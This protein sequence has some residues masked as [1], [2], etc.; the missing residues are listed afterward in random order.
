MAKKKRGGLLFDDVK[1]A[2]GGFFS[3]DPQENVSGAQQAAEL[4]LGFVPGV[5]QAL[6][7]RDFERARRAGDKAGMAL[8][9]ASLA[10]VGRFLPDASVLKRD[11]FIGPKARTWNKA[12]AE[13][14]AKLEKAGVNKEEIW[15]R[16]GTFR[17]L[18]KKWRQEISDQNMRL[19]NEFGYEPR[20][21]LDK[22]TGNKTPGEQ[23]GQFKNLIENKPLTG[24]Y[25][26]ISEYWA[27]IRKLA[28]NEPENLQPYLGRFRTK[29]NFVFTQRQMPE[30]ALDTLTHEYQHL[31]Q[32]IE[33]FPGGTNLE[34]MMKL[35]AKDKNE[36]FR[37]YQADPG[38]IEARAAALRRKLSDEQR[39]ARFPLQD[40]TLSPER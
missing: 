31:A 12:A 4:A 24:A 26:E 2:A 40:F 37:M 34:A 15:Q 28:K 32:K 17:G 22:I 19:L 16:T 20:T 25:P 36:A 3:L 8:A 9:A 14:A 11:I 13:E 23:F 35:G 29:D 38:E 27:Q 5:G 7:A 1:E 10:P 30:D 18:D 39:R 33:G 21:L 6:A